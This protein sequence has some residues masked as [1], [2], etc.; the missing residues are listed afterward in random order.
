M[1]GLAQ[2]GWMEGKNSR[3]QYNAEKRY[4]DRVQDRTI[5]LDDHH[6]SPPPDHHSVIRYRTITAMDHTC[7][8]DH[9][10]VGN[11]PDIEITRHPA[12]EGDSPTTE[13]TELA[14]RANPNLRR[15]NVRKF[16]PISPG[17]H[18]RRPIHGWN[19]ERFWRPTQHQEGPRVSNQQTGKTAFISRRTSAVDAAAGSNS[20]RKREIPVP[21]HSSISV[22]R[23]DG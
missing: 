18:H 22:S 16:P 8:P 7:S 20:S 2:R 14:K 23:R 4:V 17:T 5:D 13:Q 12:E 15:H 19:P 1:Q 3:S 6:S 9:G 11:Y 10:L 21:P